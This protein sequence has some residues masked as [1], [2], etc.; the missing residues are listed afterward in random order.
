DR[1]IVVV[2]FTRDRGSG[3]EQRQALRQLLTRGLPG[4]SRRGV[5]SVLRAG[6]LV[7]LHQV[8]GAGPGAQERSA[9]CNS[10]SNQT[11]AATPRWTN[12]AELYTYGYFL[13]NNVKKPP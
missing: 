10:Q 12:A 8:I 9:R 5:S 7:D 6:P 13:N 4:V 11:H 3:K 1:A 2:G